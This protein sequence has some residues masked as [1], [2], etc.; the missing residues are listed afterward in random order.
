MCRIHTN[1]IHEKSSIM[2]NLNSRPLA[3]SVFSS[4]FNLALCAAL[5]G[6]SAFNLQLSTVFAQGGLTPSA[7]PAPTMKTLAQIEPRTPISSLPF[8]ITNAGSYYLT[9]NLTGLV[10]VTNGIT[11]SA[12]D[13]TLDLMGFALVGGAGDGIRVSVTCTNIAVRNGTVRGWTGDGVDSANASNGQYQDLRLSANGSRGLVCGPKSTVVN[14]TAQSNTGNGIQAGLGTTVSGC[15]AAD[16]GVNGIVVSSGSTVSGCT[17]QGNTL[18]GIAASGLGS[19]VSGCTASYNT[20]D[21]IVTGTGGSTVS[22]CTAA[23]NTGD[24]IESSSDCHVVGNNCHN[25]G[26]GGD[27]AGIHATGGGNRIDGNH[28]TDNDRGIDVDLAGNLIIRNSAGGNTTSN[29]DIVAAN[30]VGVI[31]AAPDSMAI[32]G[33]TGGAGVGTTDPWANISF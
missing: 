32:I 20:G 11:I 24:G 27:S 10:G 6:L 3:G 28:V 18:N 17:A 26:N 9:T 31:V 5:L 13:V 12:G 8:N 25:N 4:R 21:G 14:C 15:A 1:P 22:G 2:K 23:Y 7:A 19:T 30:K 16:N 33:S 29:Y